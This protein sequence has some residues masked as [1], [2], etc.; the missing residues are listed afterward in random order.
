MGLHAQ[1]NHF[2]SE[3]NISIQGSIKKTEIAQIEAIIRHFQDQG[4]NTIRFDLSNTNVTATATETTPH[5]S[6][7]LDRPAC[8]SFPAC[9]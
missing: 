3:V 1:I 5:L 6:F 8:G 4:C 9:D 7:I 2:G